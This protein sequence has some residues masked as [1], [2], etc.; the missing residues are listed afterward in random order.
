MPTLPFQVVS[1][2]FSVSLQRHDI[3]TTSASPPPHSSP[4][5][6]GQQPTSDTAR[7]EPA[8][9]RC[10]FTMDC[11]QTGHQNTTRRLLCARCPVRH[12]VR[13]QRMISYS[14]F[15]VSVTF[16]LRFAKKP[17]NIERLSLSYLQKASTFELA[18]VELIPKVFAPTAAP[19]WQ[20][21]QQGG[22][23][24]GKNQQN[25]QNGNGNQQG[26]RNNQN[27]NGNQQGNWNQKQG[28]QGN[29][30]N[31]RNQQNN[32]VNKQ[33]GGPAKKGGVP[34]RFE[35]GNGTCKNPDCTFTH[36]KK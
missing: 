35:K 8:R 9:S 30:A 36:R 28:N 24:R 27:G 14:L 13:Y 15:V 33:Q 2:Y 1:S 26:N 31:Q 23:G 29:A 7:I 32:G 12:N 17:T 22:Q 4:A 3:S 10:R 16:C 25:K 21:N 20:Q 11:P 19:S 5:H 34:C 6:T 18:R